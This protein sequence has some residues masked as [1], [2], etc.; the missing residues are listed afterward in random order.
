MHHTER[1]A[2][3]PEHRFETIVPL[4][5]AHEQI[6]HQGLILNE[7]KLPKKWEIGIW[8]IQ[9]CDPDENSYGFSNNQG[10][11]INQGSGENHR[12]TKINMKKDER[13]NEWK[14]LDLEKQKLDHIVQQYRLPH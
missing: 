5:K 8:D 13:K 2:L 14:W 11:A 1:F 4:C 12:R 10:V 7:E 6:A 3:K 9:V